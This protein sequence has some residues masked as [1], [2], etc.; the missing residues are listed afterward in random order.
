M[1]GMKLS[2]RVWTNITQDSNLIQHLLSLYFC[3]EYPIFASLSK[4]HFLMDFRDGHDRFCSEILINALLSL[5]CRFSN[6][7]DAYENPNDPC[8][9]GDQFFRESKRL[10]LQESNS[11]KLTTIQALGI[12]SIREASCGRGSGSWYYAG[13]SIHLAIEMGLHQASDDTGDEEEIAVRVATFWG[14]FALDQ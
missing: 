9:A 6:R 3:W 2:P 13:Q 14:C 8:S 1:L 10:L 7:L 4:E 5:G 12:M 11:H